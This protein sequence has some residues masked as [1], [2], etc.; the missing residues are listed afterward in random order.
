M[1]K[2]TR[3][4]VIDKSIIAQKPRQY[5]YSKTEYINS[6]TSFSIYCPKHK[7]YF[8]QNPRSHMMG[9]IGCKQCDFDLVL[10]AREKG[11]FCDEHHIKKN[12][13][14][15]QYI[16]IEC[17]RKEREQQDARP[18]RKKRKKKQAKKRYKQNRET[19]LQDRHEYY[20]ENK[21]KVL[22]RDK[23]YRL[24]NIDK[25]KERNKKY[26][27]KRL[28]IDLEYRL[29]RQISTSIHN[30]LVREGGGK[31]G[32]SILDYLPYTID[33]LKTHLESLF[34]PWMTWKNWGLY[35]PHTWND[36]D[37]NTWTWQID[38][39]IPQSELLYSS[40]EDENFQ[41]SWALSN[42]RPLS[43]KANIIDGALTRHGQKRQ[44]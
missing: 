2:L 42:L 12:F 36:N 32:G 19:I 38:H 24:E 17:L 9:C 37:Q 27:K 30:A 43:A 34:E 44:Y 31:N 13:K 11:K 33:Q 15:G 40:M 6:S 4:E 21:E 5:D 8:D 23:Q 39:I 35:K 10:L 26:R 7:I 28:K 16:C 3:Q 1:Q 18:D 22:E 20:I 14:R 25:I 41:R 29:R